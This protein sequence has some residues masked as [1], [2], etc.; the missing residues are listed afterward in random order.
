A[1]LNDLK[2]LSSLGD[3]PITY[4]SSCLRVHFP[5]CDADTVEK[6]AVELGL[7][8][9][10]IGQDSDFDAFGGTE[11]AL[12]FPFASSKTV[13]EIDF[14]D[15]PV[16]GRQGNRYR[17]DHWLSE[18]DPLLFSEPSEKEDSTRS[19]DGFGQDFIEVKADANP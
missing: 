12:L 5:G 7:Q 13:S 14:Y 6:L 17:F 8:R 4:Q 2:R 11:I 9:G 19:D 10:V 3:L 1:I 16:A 15:K 18:P